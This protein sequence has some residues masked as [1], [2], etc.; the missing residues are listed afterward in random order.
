VRSIPPLKTKT[1]SVSLTPGDTPKPITSHDV[2]FEEAN[3]HIYTHDAYYGDG[4]TMTAVAKSNSILYF[5]SGNLRDF[6]FKNYTAG[7]DCVV[8]CV[9]TLRS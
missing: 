3:F 6:Y 9:A 2:F 4:T 5:R 8:V 7:N 1:I